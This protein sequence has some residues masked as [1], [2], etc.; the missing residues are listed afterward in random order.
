MQ[1]K[2][3]LEIKEIL[4]SNLS[5]DEKIKRLEDYHKS[6]IADVL[7]SFT[8]EERLKVYK[9]FNVSQLADIFPYY[10][11]AKNYVQELNPEISAD[12]LEKMDS[13]EAMDIL[14]ELKDEDK[15]EIIG[16]LEKNAQKKIIKLDSYDDETVGSHMSDNYIVIK[17]SLTIKEAMSCLVK[18]AGEHDNIY[19]I[20]VVDNENKFY[21]IINLKDLIIARKEDDLLSLCKTSYPTFYDDEIMSDCLK[22]MK[23]YGEVSIPIISRENRLLGV[24]TPDILLEANEEELIDDYAKLGGLSEN[25]DFNESA[26]V[27]VKKRI[28]WLVILMFLGLLV[29]SIVGTF[30]AVITALPA[31]V[32]FQS[33]IL[34]MAGNVRTQS[35]AVTIRNISEG[36]SEK[37]KIK[38]VFK[39]IKIG[40]I[41]GIIIGT[42]SF[43]FIMLFLII[44]HQEVVSGVGYN[45]KDVVKVS[46]IIGTSLLLSMTVS[47]LIG[48]MFPII[49]DKVHIDPAVASGPFITTFND[50][51]AV[52]SYYGLVYLAFILLL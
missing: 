29:S 41:N 17:K 22:R 38:S 31:V 50:I 18:E 40:F 5:R 24:I 9:I 35:L 26:F 21:G 15:N 27:S 36:M 25:E 45:L 1:K 43:V 8:E 6:D 3:L 16:L 42:F 48:A 47:S 37:D 33:M 49:L 34:D 20:Y 52:V 2:Y 13:D 11:N 7:E 46:L 30:E 23:D 10:D 51:I 39:E 14:D 4:L 19:T 12:I 32:F 28:P 44:K